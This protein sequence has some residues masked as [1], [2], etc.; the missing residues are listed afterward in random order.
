[1]HEKHIYVYQEAP[2]KQQPHIQTTATQ[3]IRCHTLLYEYRVQEIKS[4]VYGMGQY[5]YGKSKSK[6]SPVLE[7]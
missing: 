4:Y 3:P 7:Y 2:A 1:M 6:K 5:A